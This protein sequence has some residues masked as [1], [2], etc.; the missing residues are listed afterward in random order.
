MGHAGYAEKEAGMTFE[1]WQINALRAYIQRLEA[2]LR[3]LQEFSGF[4]SDPYPP[5]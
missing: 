2:R 1:E 4:G 5:A 3:E